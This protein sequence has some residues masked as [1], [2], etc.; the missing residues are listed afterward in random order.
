MY[1]NYQGAGG[2][3]DNTQQQQYWQP[4][5]QPQYNQQYGQAYQ[6]QD[7]QQNANQFYQPPQHFNHNYANQGYNNTQHQ[8]YDQNFYQNQGAQQPNYAQNKTKIDGWE[9]N[10]D[11]G[12]D[13]TSKQAQNAAGQNHSTAPSVQ[14]PQPQQQAFNNANVI[15]ESFASTDSWNWSMEDKKESKTPAL[16]KQE[17]ATLPVEHPPVQKNSVAE[18]PPPRSESNQSSHNAAE[19]VKTLSDRDVVKERMPNLA[20]GKR[21]HLENLTPQWSIES[22]MSQE[23]SDGP[24]T[25][26]EGTYRSDNQSRNSSKSSPGPNTDNSNF[27]YSQTGLDEF[28]PSAEWSRHSNDEATLVDNVQSGSRRES[29]DELSSSMQDMSIANRESTVPNH[30]G[31][32]NQEPEPRNVQSHGPPPSASP[33]NFLPPVSAMLP[34]PPPL[35]AN[36]PHVSSASVPNLPLPPSS[37][38]LP[39]PTNFPP[40]SS[41]NPFK[42]SGPFSHKKVSSASPSLQ[43]FPP[44]LSNTNLTS[45]SA[46]SKVSQHRMP[47]GFGANLE[48]TPDNSER[49][50][51]PA[52][53]AF[54]PMP[55]AQ[56]IP[57]NME[58]APQN[59]RNEYLQTAHLSSGDYGEN[60]DFSRS[61]PPPGLRRMVVGQQ[62]TEYSQNLNISGDEP[63]PGLA[64]MVP[65]QQ[66]ESDNS[67]N[68]PSDNYMDRH[69]DG[70]PTD[71]GG[72]PYRQADGQQTP[73]SYT[74]PPSN[75]VGERR[76]I[77]LDRMVPGEPSNDEYSQYQAPNYA[78]ANE[79][80]VVM[81]VDHD[82]PMPPDAGPS[83]IREQNVDGSDYS[84]QTPRNSS[85]NVIGARETSSN[86]S[87]DFNPAPE[88]QQ[89]EV[90]MEGEN[91]QDLSAIASVELQFSREQTFDGADLNSTEVT[92]TRTDAS[93]SNERPVTSSRR[94]SL[95]HVNT[96][97]EDSERDRAFK[98][99]PRRDRDKHN[100]TTRDRDHDRVRDK[101]GRYSS[102]GD[103]KYEREDRRAG[104]RRSEKD[105][106]ER[107]ERDESPDTR[108]HKRSTRSHRYE[109]EDTD[110]YSDRERERRSVTFTYFCVLIT[111]FR[112][113][114][115]HP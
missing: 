100:K 56:Q 106:R 8:G 33:A 83:D 112:R 27:N 35:S 69:I 29:H 9:D 79:Q 77:G 93:D 94:Q 20:L 31:K 47:V 92:A 25:H 58:V 109:T 67:F 14:A 18:T 54:R 30:Q 48:T 114:P 3:A 99:S 76:P 52:M 74:Q 104:D 72:R 38:I 105:R 51:Q 84:E 53:T 88:D 86:V 37:A 81:G 39:P 44:P 78:G 21:F 22:Q 64:R 95:N 40:T 26:S 111:K 97:G 32:S 19:E 45:P 115:Y 103:R 57:D 96:S 102:R 71:S 12:W 113:L 13:E 107:K 49:P 61:A 50:D 55:V 87:P 65:G 15:E 70:Q 2:P 68:Q 91:L 34:Q 6:H 43:S 1:P 46:V 11:W 89:R 41:T 23:S 24:Q 17:P 80:R 36:M 110:Y 108:R 75:R 4:P 101:E 28:P 63:P 60:T 73:D 7:Y 98:S 10:W 82:Y 90:T 5:Q 62:E 66:T 59:D 85:R 16:P 42:Q